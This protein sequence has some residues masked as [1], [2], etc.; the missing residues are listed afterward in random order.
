MERLVR[1]CELRPL[2]AR[3][4]QLEEEVEIALQC[5]DRG[6]PEAQI[7]LARQL[8]PVVPDLVPKP[9]TERREVA[10]PVVRR[11]PEGRARAAVNDDAA[12]EPS[13]PLPPGKIVT[14]E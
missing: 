1:P 4:V 8:P 12:E 3:L 7:V 6:E 14:H 5:R 11:E 13:P 9:R 10:I 2:P